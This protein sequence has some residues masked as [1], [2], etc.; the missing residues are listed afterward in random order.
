MRQFQEKP[1]LSII[2]IKNLNYIAYIIG[3]SAVMSKNIEH[4]KWIS[5]KCSEI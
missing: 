1:R 5:L 2:G 3:K 4:K